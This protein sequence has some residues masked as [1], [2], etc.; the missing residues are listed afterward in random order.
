MKKEILFPN[1][2]AI[3]FLQ[4]SK[5][6][7]QIEIFKDYNP[8]LVQIIKEE[9][10][11]YLVSGSELLFLVEGGININL[12]SL[13][14]STEIAYHLDPFEKISIPC[15]WQYKVEFNKPSTFLRCSNKVE[16]KINDMYIY[17]GNYLYEDTGLFIPSSAVLHL[18]N[19]DELIMAKAATTQLFYVYTGKLYGSLSDE[20]E[21]K[22]KS[23]QK[24]VIIKGTEYKQYRTKRS[25]LFQFS[26]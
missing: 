26:M 13:V 15:G 9:F 24:I 3:N 5:E 22:L 19:K 16:S 4:K 23:G 18:I 17:N 14:D 8:L 25:A 7:P 21:I 10:V 6:N 1:K 20:R 12:K 11:K 2:A